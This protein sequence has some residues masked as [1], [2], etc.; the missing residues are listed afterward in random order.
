[1]RM[2]KVRQIFYFSLL[3]LPL[4]AGCE[5]MQAIDRGIYTVTSGL[6]QPDRIR[7]ERTLSFENR[8]QQ[9]QKGNAWA[10]QFI[11]DTKAKGKRLDSNYSPVAYSR[12]ER[13]FSRIHQVSHLRG[14]SWTPVL[15]EEREWNAFTTGGTY[16]FIYSALEENLEDDSELANVIAHEMA[17]VVANHIFE[18]QSYMKVNALTDAKTVRRDTFKAAFTVENETEAD[19]VAVLYCALA[20]YNPYAGAHMWQRM[21]QTKGNNALNVS[22][23]PINSERAVQTQSVAELVSKYY[24]PGQINPQFAEILA[25]NEIF[26]YKAAPQV[27]AGKGGGILA[28]L[29]TVATTLEQQQQAKLEEAQQQQRVQFMQYVH[30]VSNIVSSA[31]IGPSRWRVTVRYEGNM[32][33][34]DMIFK[35][36]VKRTGSDLLVINQPMSGV[37]YPDSTFSVEFEST[38]LNAYQTSPQST[39]FIYDNARSL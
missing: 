29:E 6:S 9:I 26:T 24:T 25:K 21:L 35:L 32:P 10:E 12:V 18:G 11:S 37:L 34:T 27:E 17:H 36:F 33:L 3:L 22:D 19:R 38:E 23:H 30:R 31:P 2:A 5:T 8:D 7:G 20:G 39:T 4:L 15:V 13:I 1:M 28:V 14:E 16:F